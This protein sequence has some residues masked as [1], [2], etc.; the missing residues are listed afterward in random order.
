[1]LARRCR[2]VSAE[3]AICGGDEGMQEAGGLALWVVIFLDI[4]SSDDCR[5]VA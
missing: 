1:M 2:A 5:G 3:L 4:G